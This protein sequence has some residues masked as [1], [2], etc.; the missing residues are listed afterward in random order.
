MYKLL[1]FPVIFAHTQYGHPIVFNQPLS[2]DRLFKFLSM[3][4]IQLPTN[5]V[6]PP[7]DSWILQLLDPLRPIH[8][9]ADYQALVS[10]S[11][12]VAI[13]HFALQVHLTPLIGL[14]RVNVF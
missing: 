6:S 12:F 5:C 14:K 3:Q 8:S 4:N 1:S 2:S 7:H 13:G 10:N 9:M 11:E